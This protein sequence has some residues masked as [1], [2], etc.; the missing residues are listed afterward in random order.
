VS[1]D[2]STLQVDAHNSW[3]LDRTKSKTIGFIFLSG[4]ADWEYGLLAASARAWFGGAT[5]SLTADGG[6]VV[7]L[8]GFRLFPDRS[9]DETGNTDLDAVV[10]IGSDA[11]SGEAPPDVSR[12]LLAVHGRGGVVGGI[13]AGTL[14]LARS[15]LLR[16]MD[17]TSNGPDWI[18][19]HA[20]G[21]VGS[22]RYIDVPHAVS[23]GRV[24]TAPGSAPGTFALAMLSA[25]FPDRQTR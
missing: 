19:D 22:D 1:F 14:A 6:P 5:I 3:R 7:G 24:V 4:F 21:Y 10:A 13:C 20:P 8:G 25:V 12:L 16:D 17:H 23:S 2:R 15:G 18:R 9:I 11:W